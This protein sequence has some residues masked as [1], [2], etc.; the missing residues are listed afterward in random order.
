MA[1]PALT[2]L[3]LNILSLLDTSP[4]HSIHFTLTLGLT[5]P[6]K[7]HYVTY[8]GIGRGGLWWVHNP[9]GGRVGGLG[10]RSPFP[11]SPLEPLVD[12]TKHAISTRWLLNPNWG[13]SRSPSSSFLEFNWISCAWRF[14][15]SLNGHTCLPNHV[16]CRVENSCHVRMWS[17]IFFLDTITIFINLRLSLVSN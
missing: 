9:N 15:C 10:I 14:S 2:L 5:Q 4:L 16:D 8:L 12:D 6:T 13:R 3:F 1:P 17:P 11:T 7:L